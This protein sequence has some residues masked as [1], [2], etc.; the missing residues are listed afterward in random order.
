MPFYPLFLLQTKT[1]K[2]KIVHSSEALSLC[3]PA[4]ALFFYQ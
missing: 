4:V 1:G 3:F 2:G